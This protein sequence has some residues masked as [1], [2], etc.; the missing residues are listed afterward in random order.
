MQS[1][2]AVGFFCDDIREEAK[3]VI[4]IFPDNL[5]LQHVPGGIPKMGMYVRIHLASDVSA[6]KI[7]VFLRTPDG[8]NEIGLFDVEFV[9][10]TQKES[11]KNSLPLAGFVCTAI[12]AP[13][14]FNRSGQIQLIARFGEEEKVCG[15]LRIVALEET[16]V[17]SSSASQP[18]A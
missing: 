15:N 17:T 18:P 10:N 16:E 9:R 13:M 4:G 8:D 3:T 11:Q 6:Q 5:A 14:M 12:A 2:S 1:W 7:S